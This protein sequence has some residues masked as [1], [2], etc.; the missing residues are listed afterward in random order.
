MVI[1]LIIEK[2]ILGFF[3]F[4]NKILSNVMVEWYKK[5]HKRIMGII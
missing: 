1:P 5:E 4:I 2:Q 3:V